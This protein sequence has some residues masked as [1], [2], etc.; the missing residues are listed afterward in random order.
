M[1]SEMGASEVRRCDVN[2]L[3]LR[4]VNAFYKGGKGENMSKIAEV[5]GQECIPPRRR[6]HI[7]IIGNHSAGKSSF[8]NWYM[9]ADC[10]KTGVAIESQGFSLV[11]QGKRWETLKGEATLDCFEYLRALQ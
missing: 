2:E 8:I 7:M 9:G 4:E 3:I 5:F 11:T 6:V 1:G 10:L